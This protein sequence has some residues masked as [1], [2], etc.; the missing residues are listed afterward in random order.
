MSYYYQEEQ[1][2]NNQEL[3]NDLPWLADSIHDGRSK[4]YCALGFAG[5]KLENA[6]GWILSKERKTLSIAKQEIFSSDERK[7]P[8]IAYVA[9]GGMAGN[10]FAR[11]RIA[12]TR[13]LVTTLATAGTFVYCFPKTS[14]KL[15]VFTETRF[16]A[17]RERREQLC[18]QTRQTLQNTETSVN[19][20]AELAQN[21]YQDLVNRI[22]K[23]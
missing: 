7:L 18:Q 15:G 8:G 2:E 22:Y 21:Q 14:R 3:K 19:R 13:W 17:L 12:P 1:V 5:L 16:P 20:Y 9:V 6:F 10:I 4:V 11:N 23:H